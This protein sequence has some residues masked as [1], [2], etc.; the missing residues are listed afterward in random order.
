[1][2]KETEALKRFEQ[3]ED[4]LDSAWQQTTAVVDKVFSTAL[5][6][7]NDAKKNVAGENTEQV[8]FADVQTDSVRDG[9]VDEREPSPS[10]ML[11]TLQNHPIIGPI[12]KNFNP[13]LTN[14]YVVRNIKAAY[15]H[16]M[17]NFNK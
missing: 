16:L 4:W 12:W 1:M 8:T 3:L 10:D 6:L 17:E 5:T 9:A 13:D 14:Q 11:K 15:A 2:S 7:V